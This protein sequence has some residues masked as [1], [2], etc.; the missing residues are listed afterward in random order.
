MVNVS[1][2]NITQLIDALERSDLVKRVAGV[3]DRRMTNV[4]LT[5]AGLG[6]CQEMVPAVAELMTQTCAVFSQD[7]LDQLIRLLEKFRL[8]LARPDESTA[9]SP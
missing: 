2:P 7:D 6:L 1:S 3:K 8:N 4:V 5:K 9:L